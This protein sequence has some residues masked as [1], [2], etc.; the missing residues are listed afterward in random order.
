MLRGRSADAQGGTE[1]IPE[2]P[3]PG[4][5]DPLELTVAINRILDKDEREH[6]AL[7]VDQVSTSTI[8]PPTI[9]PTSTWH[10]AQPVAAEPARAMAP[11]AVAETVEEV[12]PAIELFLRMRARRPPARGRIRWSP[13]EPGARPPP[14]DLLDMEGYYFPGP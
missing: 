7:A 8:S 11:A 4:F 14:N 5:L 3:S 6:R 1:P 2:D 9:R 12:I 10:K 13:P